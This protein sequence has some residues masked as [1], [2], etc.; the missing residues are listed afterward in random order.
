[1]IDVGP[2]LMIVSGLVI[3]AMM[4]NGAFATTA[5]TPIIVASTLFCPSPTSQRFPTLL[6][7]KE[8]L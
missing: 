5:S 4:V 6:Y 8:D 2:L 3:T 7:G 1:V